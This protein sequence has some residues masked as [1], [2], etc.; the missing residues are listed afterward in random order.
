MLNIQIYNQHYVGSSGV[1]DSDP[2]S[3][4][5]GSRLVDRKNVVGRGD[6]PT[7]GGQRFP[8]GD[9]LS[10]TISTDRNHIF[11]YFKGKC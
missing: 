7:K 6:H 2:L 5:S 9:Y 11:F 4:V 8:D 10:S 3:M 1:L